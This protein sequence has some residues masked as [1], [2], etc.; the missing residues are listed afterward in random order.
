M[1]FTRKIDQRITTN[2]D[3]SKNENVVKKAHLRAKLAEV[4]GLL[5]FIEKEYKERSKITIDQTTVYECN[6]S[7]YANN[8]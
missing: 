4:K 6:E 1:N 7:N 8:F 2:F 5:L 3:T